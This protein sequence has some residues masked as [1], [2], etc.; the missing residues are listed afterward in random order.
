MSSEHVKTHREDGV[1]QVTLDRPKANA[2]D[3]ETSRA[4][5]E[6]FLAFRDDPDLR[7]AII[8]GGGEKFFCAGWDLKSA[9]AELE[10][11]E[12]DYGVGGFGGMQDLRDLNK[13]IIAAIN[14]ICCG[15]GL[16]VALDADI[17]IAA[18]HATFALPEI[19]V[20]TYAPTACIALPKRIPYHIAMELLLTGRWFDAEE[21][22][23]WGLVNRVVPA[24]ELMDEVWKLAR[25]LAEGPPLVQ[26]ATKEIVRDAENKK[27]Q[28]AL[29]KVN[30]RQ[31]R[32]VEIMIPSED[33]KEGPRAFVEKR[34]PVFR[35]R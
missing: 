15:G 27:F 31:Y 24:Q 11:L 13:P 25:K 21:A 19:T 23:R 26:A 17:L 6:V 16:E 14:G 22:H 5:G 12:E 1:L 4:M 33:R 7:V 32:S 35:G 28:D 29:N 2:I 20:G 18:D 8:T 3:T 9:G 30:A 34:K 10:V